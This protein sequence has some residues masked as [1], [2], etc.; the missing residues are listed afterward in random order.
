MAIFLGNLRSSYIPIETQDKFPPPAPIFKPLPE[1]TNSSQLTISGFAESG[2]TVKIFSS[3]EEPKE[4][5]AD[6]EGNFIFTNLKLRLG[7]NEFYA[8]AIDKE[9]NESAESKK[10][11]VYYDN[12]PPKLEII[13]PV[14]GT[15]FWNESNKTVIVGTTEPG[16]NLLI[17]D[18]FVVVDKEG[19]FRHP[20]TLSI[21]ENNFNIRATDKAGN[22]TNKNLT[23][24][25]S[26]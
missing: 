9:G 25:Y 21:G 8:T 22:Q 5:I 24:N 15:T 18:H 11:N 17:N 7:K 10:I 26:P 6:N 20:L 12:E 2:A 23:L 14:D 1:A 4:V 16:V 13:E 3:A 19:N